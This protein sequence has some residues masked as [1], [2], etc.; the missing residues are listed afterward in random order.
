MYI[1][2]LSA[3]H[4]NTLGLVLDHFTDTIGFL[5][6]PRLKTGANNKL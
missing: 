1:N 4:T 2:P 3:V 6:G 5:Q